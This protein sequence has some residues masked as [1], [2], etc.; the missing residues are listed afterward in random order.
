MN[1]GRDGDGDEMEAGRNISEDRE[2]NKRARAK[3][4]CGKERIW[5]RTAPKRDHQQQ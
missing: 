2:V 4:D 5:E 3:R 1:E